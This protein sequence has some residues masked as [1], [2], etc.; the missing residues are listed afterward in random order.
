MTGVIKGFDGENG[1]ILDDNGVDKYEF[2]VTGLIDVISI[3]DEI[4]FELNEKGF[5]INI[6]YQ[7]EL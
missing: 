2:D 4:S 3:G 7:M 1:V 6:I 5:A